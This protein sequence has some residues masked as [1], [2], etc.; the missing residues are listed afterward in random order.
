MMN[1][2]RLDAALRRMPEPTLPSSFEATVMARIARL[3]EPAQT[4]R[5][6]HHPARA[7]RSAVAWVLAVAGLLLVAGLNASAWLQPGA[8]SDLA[9]VRLM[10]GGTPWLSA[11]GI[12]A[13]LMALGL[14]LYSAGL[15]RQASGGRV[16]TRSRLS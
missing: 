7:G 8:V 5:S 6:S 1:T 10:R 12:N 11:G 9:A 16:R 2:D 15:F 13:V 14:L 4:P 3:P